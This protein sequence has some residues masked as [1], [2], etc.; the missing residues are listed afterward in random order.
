MNVSVDRREIGMNQNREE[1]ERRKS[2]YITTVSK[3]RERERTSGVRKT[4]R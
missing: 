2:Y 1:K 4:F 3:E